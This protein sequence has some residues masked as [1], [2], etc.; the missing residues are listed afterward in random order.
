MF[1]L[2]SDYVNHKNIQQLPLLINLLKW[3]NLQNW[4]NFSAKNILTVSFNVFPIIIDC[5][6]FFILLI[7]V[8]LVVCVRICCSK[9]FFDDRPKFDLI[10]SSSRS[11]KFKI[12]F[13]VID[14]LS[15]LGMDCNFQAERSYVNGFISFDP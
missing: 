15:R 2:K 9:L 5:C 4:G 10:K 8:F 11:Y 3:V 7:L 14:V 13:N 12:L 1:K 6:T